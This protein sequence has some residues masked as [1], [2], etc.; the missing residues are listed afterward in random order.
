M[1]KLM[2]PQLLRCIRTKEDHRLL[3]ALLDLDVRTDAEFDCLC[4]EY[5]D[6]LRRKDTIE[7][8]HSIDSIVLDRIYG[9]LTDCYIDRFKLK[10]ITVKQKIPQLLKLLAN[11]DYESIVVF[12]DQ[13]SGNSGV[14][15][16]FDLN[17]DNV[18]DID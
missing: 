6:I 18:D 1:V 4:E 3:V 2:E 16:S 11:Y 9:L 8:N 17:D 12:L 13:T 10:G 14:R 5:Q 7:A 15:V